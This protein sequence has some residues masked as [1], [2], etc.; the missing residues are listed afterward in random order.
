MRLRKTM[1]WR[2]ITLA[3]LLTCALAIP[4]STAAVPT[5]TGDLDAP[6]PRRD[7]T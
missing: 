6:P 3:S 7:P 4:G 5:D 2:T 1:H